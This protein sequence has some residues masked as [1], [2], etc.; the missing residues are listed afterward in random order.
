MRVLVLRPDHIAPVHR[1][2][3][4]CRHMKLFHLAQNSL[5]P[6]VLLNSDNCSLL[7]STLSPNQHSSEVFLNYCCRVFLSLSQPRL[8]NLNLSFEAG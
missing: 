5:L 4:C 8:F 1:L 6:E 3:L 2:D 7:A